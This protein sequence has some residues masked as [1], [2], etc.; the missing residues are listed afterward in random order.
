MN[1][2]KKADDCLMEKGVN[3]VDANMIMWRF[4]ILL[5]TTSRKKPNHH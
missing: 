3:R 4:D 5:I 2:F 1:Y